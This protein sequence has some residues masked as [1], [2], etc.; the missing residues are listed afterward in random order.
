MRCVVCCL[1]ARAHVRVCFEC[2]GF[3]CFAM[4]YVLHF[5]EI[6]IQEY[7]IIITEEKKLR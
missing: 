5:V 2:F 7:I 3:R 6:A 1:C 4:G